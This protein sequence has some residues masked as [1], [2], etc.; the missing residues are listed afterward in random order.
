MS[1]GDLLMPCSGAGA[2][3]L[4]DAATE[5]GLYTAPIERGEG[6]GPTSPQPSVKGAEELQDAATE[7]L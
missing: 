3:E 7:R 1:G 5:R 2:E 4:Q 6:L